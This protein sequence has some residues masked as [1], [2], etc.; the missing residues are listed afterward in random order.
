M[1]RCLTVCL[2]FVLLL[3]STAQADPPPE[4]DYQGKILVGD[5]PLT[6]P[7]Y[8][9]Y[10]IASDDGATNFWSH[11]GTAAGEPATF[12]TNECYNGVF[13]T[14]LGAPPMGD[15][16]PEIF[17]LETAMVLRVWFSEDKVT[18]NEM[19][20]PQDLLSSP[21]AI[22]AD[23]VDGLH[24]ADIVSRATNAVTLSGDISGTPGGGTTVD[25]L[26][27]DP[28][29]TGTPSADNVLI[30]D[31]AVWTSAPITV[32]TDD[33]YV[34][35]T[36]DTMTGT[37]T[38]NAAT[39]LRIASASNEIAI[40][41][42]AQAGVLG[43]AVGGDS[44]ARNTGAALGYGTHASNLA[45]AVGAYANGNNHGVAVGAESRGY[46]YGAAL[47]QQANGNGYGA[48]VGYGA[49]ATNYGVAAGYTANGSSNGAAVGYSANAFYRGAAVGS[50]ANGAQLGAAVG[51]NTRADE[52]GVAVGGLANGRNYGVAIGMNSVGYTSGVAVGSSANGYVSGVAVGNFAYGQD[53]GAGIG[54]SAVGSST[55]A[56]VGASANGAMNGAAVGASACGARYGAALGSWGY[57]YNYGAAAGYWAD[58]FDGG[59]A[60]GAYANGASTNVAVGYGASGQGGLE[61]I[62]IGHNVTN[63]MNNTARLRGDLYMDG[64]MSLWGRMPFSVGTWQ[65]LVPLP[66]LGNVVWVATNGTPGGPGT[67]DRPFDNP[68]NGYN[69]AAMKYT[70][71]PATVV[72]AAGR[73][74]A[75]NMNKGNIHVLGFDRPQL[76]FLTVS[77]PSAFILG[78]QRV[79]NI[80]ANGVVVVAVDSG[81]DVK[82]NNCRFHGGL[83]ILGPRVE[84][85]NCYARGL[86][87][88]AITVGNGASAIEEISI[89]NSSIFNKDPSNPSL[90]VNDL[91]YYFEVIGCE[92]VNYGPEISPGVFIPPY[93]AIQDMQISPL[94]PPAG[95]AGQVPHLYAHNVIHGAEHGTWLGGVSVPTV[96]DPSAL[97]GYTI[98]FVNNTVWGDVGMN[99]NVQFHANNTVYG[100]I[101]NT[102]FGMF[103]GWG[104]AGAGS[105]LDPYGNVEHQGVFPGWG[106]TQRGFPAAWQD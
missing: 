50:L 92:I 45:V 64:G 1:K 40:G 57:G 29:D 42:N 28:L 43:V 30:W 86:D 89:Y 12:I 31:G 83:Q 4:F 33:L 10:A 95:P 101:N 102:G 90:L 60:L 41:N 32:V 38:I 17:A 25:S 18:F 96:F 14:I 34:D 52:R 62:A 53:Y 23:M 7:G 94:S 75:L 36:G 63:D 9:K 3:A 5:I 88:P 26:Q 55:G 67:I 19:L 39:G 61:R 56:A 15:I 84:V 22:N 68:Q 13:S 35:E 46:D 87:G 93:A 59:A 103:W 105:G 69:A 73:Y 106:G 27:G 58:G 44:D 79:E 71:E 80:I 16:D 77:A 48:A 74:P 70:N 97:V 76:S 54:S 47:G 85:M 8:F 11:D 65:R 82:F 104:Q 51:Y 37:L 2:S 91:V 100:D 21:Y 24:A 49:L 66:D 98:C 81:S 72:I 6:G 99:S 78:K 20:P